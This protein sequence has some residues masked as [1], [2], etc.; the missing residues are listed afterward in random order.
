MALSTRQSEIVNILRENGTI[1]VTSLARRLNVST[2]SI[3][4]DVR[5]LAEA[6]EAVKRHG[7][8]ALPFELGEAPFERRMHER[9]AAKRAIARR[10]A[11]LIE[12]GDSLMLDSG[13]TTSIFARELLKKR[14]LTIVTNASDIARTLATVNGNK[15][16]MAGGE[17]NGDDGAAFGPA[18]I[19]F[20]SSFHVRHAFIS[21]GGL[22]AEF[23]PSDAQLAEAEF[24]RMVLSRGQNRIILSDRSKFGRRMLIKICDF[25]GINR[26]ICDGPP[27]PALAQALQGAKVAVN[28]VATQREAA[29][30]P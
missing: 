18:A 8:V 24:A 21:V 10:A 9:V 25:T 4:R 22:D 2:E 23:G 27:D 7:S 17:L 29:M 1:A 16:Y 28:V 11:R 12:D 13:T 20:A 3:R 5:S 6:R 19:A 30:Q 15:V 26:L 14:N